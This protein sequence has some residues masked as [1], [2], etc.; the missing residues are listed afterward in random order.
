MALA[1]RKKKTFM[2]NFSLITDQDIYLYNEGTHLQLY[3][4][5]GAHC[6]TVK[7]VPGT[8]F[9]VW[10]PNA[11]YVS[12]I[13]DFNGWDKGSTPM[14]CRGGA[15]IWEVFVPGVGQ[16]CRYKY[17]ISSHHRGY[18]VE[19]AD[20]CGAYHEVPPRTASIVWDFGFEWDDNAWMRDR[21]KRNGLD[22][23]MSVY[24]VHPESWRRVPE[25]HNRSLSYRE[26]AHQLGEY[27]QWMGYTHVE[28]MPIMEYPFS[29]SWGYQLTGYFAPSSR[30][31]TPEDFAYFVNHMHKLGIGVI[32][33]WVP[34]HFPTDQHGLAY[35]DGTH[36][37]E[38]E[39]P[40]KG[41][42]P[43]WQSAIFNYGRHE[44]RS[45]LLS[46][47]CIWMDRYHID[48]LRVDAVASMLYLDYSRKA[49]EWIPNHYGGNENLEAVDFLRRFNHDI[50]GRF[51]GTF[52]VAEESTA[53]PMVSR[54]T[55]VGGL[56]FTMK[57]DMGWMHDTLYYFR[58]SGIHRK[59]HQNTLT[60]RMLYA[61]TENFMLPLSHDEVVH[62][63][64]SLINQMGGDDPWQKFANLRCLF[65][66]MYGTPGK[67]L[68]FMGQEFGQGKE[69]NYHQSL[70]WH[71]THMDWHRGVQL[72]MRDLN[73]FYQN[74]PALYEVD[75]SSEG[76]QW[77]DCNDWESSVFSFIR[78]SKSGNDVVLVV[79]NLTSVP[80]QNYRVGVPFAGHWQE[81]LNSDSPMYCGS[82]MGNCGG[83]H[84]DQV[85]CHH[86][87]ASLNLTLPPL[88]ACYFKFRG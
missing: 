62:G 88:S 81:V 36:L 17:F 2:E 16:G 77:M 1:N 11:Q 87:P 56:G 63:K 66:Y 23:P 22:S 15:G 51:P 82:G 55:Y 80:R 31:G 59:F 32:L 57:W 75:V 5:L 73:L 19:K 67:K 68:T 86:Q 33:D 58:K 61:F 60:F 24:E 18:C 39:D 54:P 14:S 44:V 65:G 30:F 84:A 28:L 12:V 85:G 25:D 69:W 26:M 42:H 3:D 45:F 10:A 72:W 9:A 40:R 78:R 7:G 79:L 71:Q 38:H 46:S 35:F 20:P 74:E 41:F 43:D 53:W 64:G 8:F 47:A 34:S 48:G 27:V 21:W 13:A 50:H 29:G 76:F 37:Y 70:D 52:T 83:F 4:K 6:V 49:G